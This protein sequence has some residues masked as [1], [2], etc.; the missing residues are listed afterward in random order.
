[1]ILSVGAAR[2]QRPPDPH[3]HE[4]S[5]SHWHSAVK[6]PRC[7]VEP[8]TRAASLVTIRSASEHAR[9]Q[10]LPRFADP[11]GAGPRSP[12]STSPCRAPEPPARV[13]GDAE[14]SCRLGWTLD[15]GICEPAGVRDVLNC[16]AEV[17]A[18]MS[19]HPDRS[20]A[21]APGMEDTPTPTSWCSRCPRPTAPAG[22]DPERP[23]VP[24]RRG[25]H[26]VA[27]ALAGRPRP[28]PRRRAEPTRRGPPGRDRGLLSRPDDPNHRRCRSWRRL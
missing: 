26:T 19:C 16:L 22:R 11:R 3:G 4:R 25:A 13:W 12:V 2:S 14:H 15:T 8:D 7:R 5:C 10:R 9:R 23:R 21:F 1:M 28:A 17:P 24:P 18:A 27:L 20:V 6:P